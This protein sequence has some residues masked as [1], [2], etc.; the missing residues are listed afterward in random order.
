MG[1]WLIVALFVLLY[2]GISA[3]AWGDVTVGILIAFFALWKALRT[4]PE[5]IMEVS[6]IVSLLGLWTLIS[7]F[8]LRYSG[9]ALPMWN[10]VAVGILVAVL[11]TYRGLH[12]SSIP[13]PQHH[14]GAQR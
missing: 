2:R 14:R 4:D 6:W 9:A 12:R 3:A 1:I 5:A 7:P 8:V 13:R 10:N 11:A